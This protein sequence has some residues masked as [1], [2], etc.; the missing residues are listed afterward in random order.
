MAYPVIEP[1]GF[2]VVPEGEY[3]CNVSDIKSENFRHGDGLKF[4]FEITDGEYQ[5]TT[6]TGITSHAWSSQ[7]KLRSWAK[8]ILQRDWAGDEQLDS[9]DLVDQPCRIKVSEDEKQV[10]DALMTVNT[11]TDVLAPVKA[12]LKQ[13]TGHSAPEAV[14]AAPEQ[15]SFSYVQS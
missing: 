4:S 14:A 2:T 5:G 7:S 10:K 8:G 9:G 12:Q 13:K 1:T 6:I 15:A 3:W 11:I